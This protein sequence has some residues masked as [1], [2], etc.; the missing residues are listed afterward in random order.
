[1]GSWHLVT[2]EYPPEPGGVA[3]YTAILAQALAAVVGPVH[4]WCPGNASATR[5]GA[6]VVHRVAGRFGPAGLWR[7]D[8]EIGR[9]PGPRTLLVQYTPHAYGYKAMNLPFVAWVASRRLR[10]DDV[11]AMF[12]EVTYPWVR[13]PWRHNLIAAVNRLM[14]AVL[15]R[16][17]T[18]AY[19]SIPAWVPLLRRLGGA[20]LPVT[21]TPVPANVPDDP[22]PAAVAA[23]RAELGGGPLVGHFGTY[24]PLIVALLGPVL[25]ALFDRRPD[26]RAVLLGSGGERW[27]AGFVADRPDLAPRVVAPGALPALSVA[28]YLRACDLAVQPYPDGASTRRSS[29]MAALA[30][31]VPVVTNLGALSEPVWASGPVAT[32]PADRLADLAADLLDQSGRRSELGAAGRRI[33]EN[34]FSIGRTV[35]ALLA[36]SPP[37]VPPPCPPAGS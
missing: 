14:A 2:G 20:R 5:E 8:R 18:R 28:E 13:R 26:V 6:V 25:R 29:L 23:R 15:V 1:V 21:W 10:G 16:A 11:R 31:A 4:V 34:Q 17:C 35:A 19:V 30:N 36:D 37:V 33:Y 32:A 24:G 27:R 3:D 9:L 22:A 7:L 12:H